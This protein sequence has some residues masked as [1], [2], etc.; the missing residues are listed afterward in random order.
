MDI[1][2]PALNGPVT[3]S[4]SILLGTLTSMTM[5]NLYARQ[6]NL[7]RHM[8]DMV[9]EVRLLE[10]HTQSFPRPFRER[11]LT[12]LDCFLQSVFDDATKGTISPDSLRNRTELANLILLLNELSQEKNA[13]STALS[14]AYGAINRA[15]DHRSQIISL[16]QNTF[17]IWHYG[18]LAILALAIC[19]IFLAETDMTALKFLAG[20]QLKMCWSMLVGSFSMMATVIL[21]LNT[22]LSGVFRVR[23]LYCSIM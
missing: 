8:A 4:I 5:S 16:Y 1:I 18:N 12:Q 19:V 22:P 10:L 6:T 21:D 23:I 14:E 7:G 3:L 11:A 15:I 2:T 20:F 9:D 17:P 13:P